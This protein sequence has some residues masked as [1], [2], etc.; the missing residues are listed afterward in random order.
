MG[1]PGGYEH[2]AKFL[3]KKAGVSTARKRRAG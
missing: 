2:I 3:L 1:V